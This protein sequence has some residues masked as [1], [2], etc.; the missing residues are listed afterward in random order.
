M[1]GKE[2][3]TINVLLILQVRDNFFYRPERY[4]MHFPH[5]SVLLISFGLGR[6][7][8]ISGIGSPAE[9]FHIKRCK[10]NFFV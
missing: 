9:I 4:F 8:T 3:L 5:A 7:S 2:G 1:G 6:V 10:I